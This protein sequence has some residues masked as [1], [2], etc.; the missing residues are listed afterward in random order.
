MFLKDVVFF[1][2]GRYV[3][4]SRRLHC[5]QICWILVEGRAGIL[6]IS[7]FLTNRSRTNSSSYKDVVNSSTREPG[8]MFAVSSE[9]TDEV[10]CS[11][12]GLQD[13]NV[14]SDIF[15][16]GVFLALLLAW[17]NSKNNQVG[18]FLSMMASTLVT[19]NSFSHDITFVRNYKFVQVISW[20]LV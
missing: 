1:S 3:D 8:P 9:L 7:A 4:W 16:A 18:L 20:K 14:A 13:W 5:E 17:S 10:L 6:N 15:F 2:T 11:A 19:E 12:C